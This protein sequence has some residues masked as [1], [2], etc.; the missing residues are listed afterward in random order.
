MSSTMLPVPTFVSVDED[1]SALN[2]E[3]VR[4]DFRVLFVYDRLE[5]VSVIKTE[6]HDQFCIE[7]GAEIGESLVRWLSEPGSADT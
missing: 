2:V 4:D 5:G 3:W 6:R 7:D 1:G